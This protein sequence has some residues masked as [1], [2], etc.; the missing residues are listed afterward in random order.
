[1][2]VLQSIAAVGNSQAC[3]HLSLIFYA[4][5][6]L[7]HA[8]I[9]TGMLLKWGTGKVFFFNQFLLFVFLNCHD[10][11]FIKVREYSLSTIE[12]LRN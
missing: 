11:T 4:F 12:R 10:S 8:L 7:F 6:A 2:N 9:A 1:V 5:L 3:G